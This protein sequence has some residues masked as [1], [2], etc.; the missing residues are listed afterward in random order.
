MGAVFFARRISHLVRQLPPSRIPD[1]QRLD[2][3]EERFDFPVIG[4]RW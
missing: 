4:D 2:P 1:W 3:L